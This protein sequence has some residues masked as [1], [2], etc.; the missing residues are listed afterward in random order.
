MAAHEFDLIRDYFQHLTA[1]RD[2]VIL[3]IGDDCALLQ[4]PA[5]R[6]LA[7]TSDTL[8]AGC[9]FFPD[10][11]AYTLGHKSLAVN[12]SDLA[13]MGATP[14]W[15]TLSLTLPEA[16][17]AWIARF[18]EGFASLA[19]QYQ[20]QLI[21]GDMSRGPLSVTLT[22]HGHI[23]AGRALR[24][25]A[26]GTGQLI[27]VSG[28]LGEA[29][30][31]LQRLK[32]GEVVDATARKPL[33]MPMP[34]VMLGQRLAGAASAC[35]DISDG[36]LAD[37]SH[38]CRQSHCGAY[39]Y[40]D[41]IPSPAGLTDDQWRDCVLGGGDDYQLCFTLQASAYPALS[42]WAQQHDIAIAIIG[43]CIAAEIIK[44]EYADGRIESFPEPAG[45]R[46]F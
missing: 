7:V 24:R 43:E 32:S 17:Q 38:V 12:L 6:Q 30:H 36:L 40:A 3:G 33:E 31:V 19:S 22:L 35:I 28:R 27:C 34:Q 8:V 15:A 9:H 20:L 5:G 21:G 46:H 13:A 18:S 23:D 25:D 14:C 2:D 42:K 44:L 10:V 1:A 45:Y 29:A 4:P 26:A 11:D 41:K 39:L 37:L 16:D